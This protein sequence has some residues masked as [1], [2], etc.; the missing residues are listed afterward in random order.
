VIPTPQVLVL[1]SA[2]PRRSDLL[3]R[4]GLDFRVLPADVD[5]SFDPM[6]GA[7]SAACHLAERKARAVAD[8][9]P[10]PEGGPSQWILGG[11]TLVVLGPDFEVGGAPPTYLGK[12]NNEIE[13]RAMLA[14][15]SETTHR[16][17]TGV[18]VLRLAGAGESA[19]LVCAAETT[20]VTMRR[21][22]EVEQQA[23]VD[24]GE[25]RGKAGGY[26]IQESADQFVSNLEGGGFDNVVGLPV[27][28]ALR[29][30]EQT[31]FSTG[32]S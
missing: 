26:A 31:G 14:S 28:L 30:L 2:S 21:I 24:S 22:S 4:A 8:L 18:A 15:L 16:V 1:G 23:Y 25:W 6:F 9:L 29:L 13:A 3:R 10:K 7:V 5:E 12:P 27:D 32:R 11:D 20:L 17:V 19:S